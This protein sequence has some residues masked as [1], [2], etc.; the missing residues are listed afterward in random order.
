MLSKTLVLLKQQRYTHELHML[1]C[2]CVVLYYCIE[3]FSYG[4]ICMQK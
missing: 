3:A 2:M 1:I 4:Q